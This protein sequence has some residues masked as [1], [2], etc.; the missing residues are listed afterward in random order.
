MAAAAAH[1]AHHYRSRMDTDAHGEPHTPGLFQTGV[2]GPHGVEDAQTGTHGPLGI[3]FMRLRIAKVDQQAIAQI[4]GNIP[5]KTLEHLDTGRLIGQHDLTEVF[6]VELTGEAGGVGQIAEQHRELTAL[7]LRRPRGS[8]WGGIL[9]RRVCLPAQAT[10]RVIEYLRMRVEEFVL[11]DRELRVIEVELE[12][13]RVIRH[14]A[15]PLE[16]SYDLVEY[17]VKLHHGT[18]HW[19]ARTASP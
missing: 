19:A 9:G 3:I 8:A 6:R 11:Q 1:G 2:Q 4:L 17:V 5:V 15:A 16:Q 13:Q 14:S 18:S 12:L 7:G 10:P